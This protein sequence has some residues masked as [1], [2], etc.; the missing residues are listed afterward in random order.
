MIWFCRIY[1]FSGSKTMLD[2]SI[3]RLIMK[4]PRCVCVR[5][6]TWGAE[7]CAA[8]YTPHGFSEDVMDNRQKVVVCGGG[9]FIGGHL[10]GD[11]LSKGFKDIR[12]VDVKPTKE[13]YQVHP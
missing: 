2:A 7:A 13:W 5:A 4:H 3:L 10:V 6:F 8:T 12:V 9:G 1:R 11:L